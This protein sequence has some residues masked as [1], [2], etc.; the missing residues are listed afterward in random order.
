[1]FSAQTLSDDKAADTAAEDDSVRIGLKNTLQNKRINRQRP[2]TAKSIPFVQRTERCSFNKTMANANLA[3]E[4]QVNFE[5]SGFKT[6]VPTQIDGPISQEEESQPKVASRRR[7]TSA[8]PSKFVPSLN[9]HD[10]TLLFP[11]NE[12]DSV[13]LKEVKKIKAKKA[14]QKYGTSDNSR[15][16]E[17]QKNLRKPS[18][19]LL[20]API[21]ERSEID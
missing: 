16:S 14:V 6:V 13:R 21:E 12:A 17:K 15:R 18:S 9:K 11:S 10:T 19:H 20:N 4:I 8:R 7:I 3:K 1:M 2:M 5:N